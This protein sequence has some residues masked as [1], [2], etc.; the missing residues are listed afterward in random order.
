M[1][2][3]VVLRSERAWSARIDEPRHIRGWEVSRA[4]PSEILLNDAR[5]MRYKFST[6]ARDFAR[7]NPAR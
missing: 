5:Y 2:L 7:L 1:M 4:L 6:I 3:A